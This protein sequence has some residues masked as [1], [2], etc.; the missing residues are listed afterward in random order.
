MAL[1]SQRLMAPLNP[2]PCGLLWLTQVY[3]YN[4]T[5]GVSQWERPLVALTAGDLDWHQLSDEGGR[6]Y[7]H[8]T[9]SG[10]VAWELP[11]LVRSS[12]EIWE[13]ARDGDGN[14]YY[15]NR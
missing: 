8:N 15:W 1:M 12:P 14:S 10:E 7:Y 3:F 4:S 5:T 2:S 9:T 11:L 13:A 6:P